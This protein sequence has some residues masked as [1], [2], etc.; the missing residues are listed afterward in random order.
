M[1]EKRRVITKSS[2]PD[3]YCVLWQLFNVRGEYRTVAA[4][5]KR[6]FDTS[7]EADEY[8]QLL[9]NEDADG[10]VIKWCHQN[11]KVTYE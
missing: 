6:L 7:K 1:I 5:E 2:S 8:S 4:S 11:G 3:G 9:E 10:F